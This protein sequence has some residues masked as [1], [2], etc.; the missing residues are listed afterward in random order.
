VRPVEGLE[1][2]AKST[3]TDEAPSGRDRPHGGASSGSGA[4]QRWG[5]VGYG[6]GRVGSRHRELVTVFL[7]PDGPAL[8]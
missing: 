4:P 3:R 6:A 5:K 1:R 7:S 8:A 2:P